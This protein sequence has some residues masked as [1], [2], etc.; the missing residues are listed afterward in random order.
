MIFTTPVEY[1][2]CHRQLI[3]QVPQWRI[4]LGK[5]QTT[6]VLASSISFARSQF[7]SAAAPAGT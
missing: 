4:L 5:Y 1:K 3:A 7:L 2:P 6:A